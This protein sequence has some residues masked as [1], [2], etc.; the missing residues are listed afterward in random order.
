MYTAVQRTRA[1]RRNGQRFL[2]AAL[3]AVERHIISLQQDHQF[4]LQI[5][6]QRLRHS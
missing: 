5:F 4:R 6:C 2:C 3:L 1:Y